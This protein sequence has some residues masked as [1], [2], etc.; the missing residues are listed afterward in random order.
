MFE[1]RPRQLA[2][3]EMPTGAIPSSMPTLRV[4]VEMRSVEGDTGASYRSLL[5]Y[6][7][8]MTAKVAHS[9]A[10]PALSAPI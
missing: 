4:L 3:A 8:T 2:S 9:V 10:C 6:R 5:G 1:Q 7:A